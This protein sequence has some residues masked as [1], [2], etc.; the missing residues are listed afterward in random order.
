M[1]YHSFVPGVLS[2]DTNCKLHYA[3]V[4]AVFLTLLFILIITI[5]TLVNISSLNET[6]QDTR[7]LVNDMNTLLPDAKFG[8]EML[9]LLCE[10]KNFTNYYTNVREL[11][12]VKI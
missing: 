6:L 12:K 4:V 5:S 3:H 10:N 8:L 9:D 1:E 7:R 11:C 2:K